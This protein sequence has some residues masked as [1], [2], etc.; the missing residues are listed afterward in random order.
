MSSR[1][2]VSDHQMPHFVTSTVVGWIDAL[3]R[4]WYKQIICDSLVYCQKE[5]GMILHAW[6]IMNNHIHLIIS[7][8]EGVRIGNLMRDFKKF[9]SKKIIKAIEENVQE[10]RREW[11][12][13]MFR[14]AGRQNSNN[15]EMQ[16]WQQDYH[17]VILDTEEKMRQRLNYLNENPV[18]TGIVWQAEHYKYSSAIDYYENKQGLIPITKL[19]V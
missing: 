15:E 11:M 3:S 14:F 16:F 7:A 1:Y 13:N 2:K 18:R 4:E 5:K 12:L 17:P 19:L 8:Q 6:V 10:S 9:T